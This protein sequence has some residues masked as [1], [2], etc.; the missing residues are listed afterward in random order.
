MARVTIEDCLDKSE[1]RFALV[2]IAAMRAR[3]IA[4][5]SQPMVDAKNKEAVMALREIAAGKIG[6]N[7]DIKS[8]LM[9]WDK[10]AT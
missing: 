4:Q 7:R 9:S 8:L 5:G 1:N 3:Q 10:S 6:F 2:R